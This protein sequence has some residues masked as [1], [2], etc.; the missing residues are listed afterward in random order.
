MIT[1]ATIAVLD[2][3]NARC[4]MCDIWQHK[5]KN[6]LMPEEYRR[7]PSTLKHVNIGG[8]EPFMR[9]DLPE[10]LWVIKETCPQVR[11]VLSTN[12]FQ[13]RVVEKMI[14]KMPEIA[15]RVSL[16]GVGALHDE[17]RRIKDGYNKVLETIQILKTAGVK[18]LGIGATASKVNQH[19]FYEIK[20]LADKLKVQFTCAVVH[21]SETTFG[22]HTEIEAEVPVVKPELEKIRNSFLVSGKPKDWARGY[23]VDTLID[24]LDKKPRPIPCT[25]ADNFFFLQSNGDVYPCNILN[26][27]MGNLR[28]E[29]IE[30]IFA[31][32]QKIKSD[33][34]KCNQC[35]MICTVVPLLRKNPV[36]PLAWVAKNKLAYQLGKPSNGKNGSSAVSSPSPNPVT[37]VKSAT[38]ELEEVETL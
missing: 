33:C 37:E 34:A 7:L 27:K 9:K 3:C 14:A 31:R 35:W 36:K 23:F 18:D 26:L 21:N 5:D 6:Y 29:R 12:G 24:Y 20:E 13:P 8:G 25:A 19:R 15:I 10:L 38:P 28:E 32:N 4:V 22:N 2:A 30:E 11:M 1:D 16:D 17:V